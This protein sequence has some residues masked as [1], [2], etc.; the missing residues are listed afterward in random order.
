MKFL[1][2]LRHYK[3]GD[4]IGSIFYLINLE[5]V[6]TFQI[7]VSPNTK[8]FFLITK[9]DEFNGLLIG[10]EWLEF[11]KFISNEDRIFHLNICDDY[12]LFPLND[13]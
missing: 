9:N 6:I 11:E 12:S 1:R 10:F 5:D 13:V 2:I 7:D 8:E 3:Y 4:N